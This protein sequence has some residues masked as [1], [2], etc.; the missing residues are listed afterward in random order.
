MAKFRFRL[1]KLTNLR[2][3]HRNEL[4]GKHAEAIQAQQIL[5]SQIGQVQQEIVE[6]ENSRRQAVRG[7]ATDVNA[8]LAFQ[9]YQAVLQGQEAAMQ[10]Q[11]QTLT[12]E[13][14]RRR[15]AVV[16]ADRQVKVLEKLRDRRLREFQRE[17][18]RNQ[19]RFLDEVAA[20]CGQ[21]MDKWQD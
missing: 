9:R 5:E 18:L 1:E 15:L 20:R 12:N 6:L 3:W 14:E 21:E 10:Q 4:Q 17:Q 13:A 11:L 8:L 19:T 7:G 16:E 2:E